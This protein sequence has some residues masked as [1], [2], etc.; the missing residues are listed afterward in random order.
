MW[1][2]RGGVDMVFVDMALTW[3][4][5]DVRIKKICVGLIYYSHKNI[6]GPT[7]MWVQHVIISPLLLPP[8]SLPLPLI[9]LSLSL[10]FLFPLGQWRQLEQRWGVGATVVAGSDGGGG[11]E[12]QLGAEEMA[13]GGR[14]C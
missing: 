13:T 12:R 5:F 2:L 6:V 9:S 1:H 8:L 10:S 4:L 3:R 11:W 14:C 7:N